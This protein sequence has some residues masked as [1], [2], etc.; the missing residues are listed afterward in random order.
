[1]DALQDAHSEEVALLKDAHVRETGALVAQHAALVLTVSNDAA[2][3]RSQVR[4]ACACLSSIRVC[5]VL[6]RVQLEQTGDLAPPC[7]VHLCSM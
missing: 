6:Q 2:E 4:T 5:I 1:M 3:H 7:L